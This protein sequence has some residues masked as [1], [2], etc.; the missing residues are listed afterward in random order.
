[1]VFYIFRRLRKMRYQ[2]KKCSMAANY[3]ISEEFRRGHKSAYK[4]TI[5]YSGSVRFTR[6]SFF[7]MTVTESDLDTNVRKMPITF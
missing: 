3:L 6:V 2:P 4:I 1:M 5:T 7:N